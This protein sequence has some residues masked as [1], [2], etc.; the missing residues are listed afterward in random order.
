MKRIDIDLIVRAAARIERLADIHYGSMAF[1]EI[2]NDESFG[3]VSLSYRNC[4]AA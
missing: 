1:Q 3:G 2:G 4:E